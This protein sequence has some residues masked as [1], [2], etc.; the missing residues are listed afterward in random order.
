MF[1]APVRAP[2]GIFGGALKEVAA[3]DLGVGAI[4]GALAGAGVKRQAVI[5]A[6]LPV[7]VP[8][9]T[10]KRFCGSAAQAIV[11]AAQEILLGR[12]DVEI[13]GRMETTDLAPTSSDVADG[14]I[15][16]ATTS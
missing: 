15:A 2:I 16:W 12:A 4:K 8:A 9:I 5:A 13:A 14:A 7:T 1:A 10:V 6:G 3:P 11:C